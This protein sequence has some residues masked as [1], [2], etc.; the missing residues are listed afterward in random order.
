MK[1]ENRLQIR[2]RAAEFLIFTRPTGE[3]ERGATHK[4]FSSVRQ[5]GA[6]SV[7]RRIPMHM[8]EL[9]PD[10]QAERQP[11]YPERLFRWRIAR[12]FSSQGILDHC[13]ALFGGCRFRCVREVTAEANAETSKKET[14]II[15]SAP[16]SLPA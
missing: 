5:E 11:A 13:R 9:F 1:K 3:L 14:A 12:G 10:F 8:A 15:M 6:R 7:Q 16:C 4:D 2:N